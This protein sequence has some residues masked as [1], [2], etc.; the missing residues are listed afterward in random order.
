MLYTIHE[1][2]YNN[3]V[4][5]RITNKFAIVRL[6]NNSL[7]YYEFCN[8]PDE[9]THYYVVKDLYQPYTPIT[10][11]M[12]TTIEFCKLGELVTP[13]LRFPYD[14]KF[15]AVVTDFPEYLCVDKNNYT[16]SHLA[17]A[18]IISDFYK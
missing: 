8:E 2:Q 10:I 17:H 1:L 9:E 12:I 15:Y 16:P 13:Q 14:E 7:P 18:T 4:F 6:S 11:P 5:D 3:I